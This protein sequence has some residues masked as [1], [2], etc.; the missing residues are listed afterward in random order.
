MR[1]SPLFFACLCTAGVA[2]AGDKP[3][4]QPAPTWI[5]PAPPIDAT[6]LTDASPA[7]V[8][9][10]NQ[11]RVEN[12]QVWSYFDTATR[13]SSAQVLSE[14][15]DVKL[16]WQPA[17]GDLVIHRAEIVRGAQ[18]ID[19]LKGGQPFTVLRR[20]EQLDQR[21]LDGALTAMMNAEGLSAGDVLHVSFSTTRRDPTL[22]GDAQLFAGLV[23]A[24]AQIGFGRVRLVWPEKT[25]LKWRSYAEGVNTT[26]VVKDGW[27]ELTVPLP[28]AKQPEM[29]DDAPARFK[30]MPMLEA[31]TFAD[32]AAVSK[33]MAP[34]YAT[35]GAIAPGSPLAAEVA[36]IKA[37]QAQPLARAAL[38]LQSVQDN[39][40]YLVLGMD[41]G[42]YVP[43]PAAQTWER[44]YGDCKAKTLLLLAMLHAMDIEAEPVLASARLPG[45]VADRLASPGAFDHVLVRATIGGESLWLDGTG[46]GT[47]LADIRDT[48]ALGTV[49]PVRM[50]GATLMPIA[51]HADARPEYEVDLALDDSAGVGLPTTFKFAMI[52]RGAGAGVL[53][54]ASAQ[55]GAKEREQIVAKL[56]IDMLG[57]AQIVDPVISYDSVNAQVRISAE[58]LI[59]TQWRREARRYRT[60]VDRAINDVSFEPDRARAAWRNIPV[61]LSGPQTA[62]FRT[63]VKLPDG[64][65]GYTLEGD[66]RL[67]GSVAG[68]QVSRKV[69]LSGDTLTLEDRIV[70][71]GG[72]MPA[73]QIP[74]AKA[75]IAQARNGMLRLV[76]P[77]TMPSRPEVVQRAK[78]NGALATLDRLYARI[79]ANDPKEATAYT[80]RASLRAGVYDRAG[81]IADYTQAIAL[82]PTSDT[83]LKRAALYRAL[84]QDGKSLTDI[85]AARTLE[86]GS[87]T[88]LAMLA[89]HKVRHG[90]AA[91][92]MAMIQER[93]DA[94]GKDA[95]DWASIKSDMLAY[96]GKNDEALALLD[97]T[98]KE[99]G[100]DADLLNARCW[101]KATSN[102]ALESAL[103]DCAKAIE[104]SD[105][106]AGSLDSRALVYFRMNRLDDALL[107]LDAAIDASPMQDESL[108]MR[109]IVYAR[110]GKQAEAKR[111]LAAARSINPLV[112]DDYKRWGIVAQ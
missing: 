107:D 106:P 99:R 58:G 30:R 27:R 65:T 112:D 15:G 110:L 104:L 12:G 78:A 75:R 77:V 8:L 25:E 52:G 111:D 71:V 97:A 90:D 20:E 18:R 59:T 37:A 38:A 89:W 35:D 3:L 64:G 47:R 54:A 42:N 108:F 68:A 7:L 50:A 51:L 92:G 70:R 98:L 83:Y 69:A 23:T 80:S 34:L 49:L 43:Q 60:T 88:A 19:L 102:T 40:R 105:S 36:R 100:A 4:Y 29:P 84:R 101:Q 31:T 26:P 45:M 66:Q 11:Q 53:A 41:T 57:E 94:G 95:A 32:W 2:H 67:D 74:I 48:P 5:A 24:P 76:A 109:G 55:V 44:R 87:D 56:I 13:A 10:D 17:Q 28:L 33:V 1:R 6:K 93:I 21:Q 73:D 63:T 81:A 9:L 14:I 39:I 46:S 82:E 61:A 79:V 72:E 86:P 22:K 96:Q 91:A 85:E 62:I 16:Q 103:K